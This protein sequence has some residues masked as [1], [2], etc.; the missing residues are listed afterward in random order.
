[1]N[2]AQSRLAQ[3]QHRIRQRQARSGRDRERNWCATS[4]Q[5]ARLA[6]VIADRESIENGLRAAASRARS[7]PAVGRKIAG[8][9]RHQGP[10]ER[11]RARASKPRAP[12]WKRRP[13]STA[14]ASHRRAHRRPNWTRCAPIWPMC[15][16]RSNGWKLEEAHRDELREAINALNEETAALK[17]DEQSALRRDAGASKRAST[18]VEAAEAICPLCGQPLDEEHKTALLDEIAGRRD[19]TRRHLPRQPDPLREKSPRRSRPT[20]PRSTAIEIELRRLQALRER[21]A[22]LAAST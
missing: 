1:M 15:R 5:L 13:A 17:A 2:A 16:P 18:T 20:A 9:E 12:N 21:A 8:D 19:R 11:C 3:A 4:E 14:T 22:A 10:A 7:R 6:G